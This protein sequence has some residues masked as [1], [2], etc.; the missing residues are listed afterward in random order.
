MGVFYELVTLV[1]RAPVPLTV[2][3]DGQETT[4]HPGENQIPKIAI[5][6]AKNQNPIMGTADADNPSIRGGQYLVGVKGTED[7]CTPLT[8]QEWE[9]H[10]GKPSRMNVD[11]MIVSKLNPKKE[12]LIVRGRKAPSSFEVRENVQTEFGDRD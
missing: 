8:K 11:D 6:C 9:T 10:L 7:D 4:I 1:N 5:T 2:R 3:F 12:R